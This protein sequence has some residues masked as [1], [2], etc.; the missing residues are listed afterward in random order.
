MNKKTIL[1]TGSGSGIGLQ[2][3]LALARRGHHVIASDI[4]EAHLEQLRTKAQSEHLELV[5]L[6]LDITKLADIQRAADAYTIDTLI[7]NAGIGETGPIAEVPIERIR[8]NFEVNVFGTIQLIQA[9]VPQMIAKKQG[10]I[11]IMSSM[12]GLA[13]PMFFSPYSASKAALESV[14]TS[15]RNEL[16]Y[17]NIKVVLLNPGRIDGGHNGRIAQTKY[18]W[19]TSQSPYY[20]L[21][22]EM[23]RHDAL[24]LDNAYSIASV[25]P[26]IVSAVES[27]RPRV[28]YAAPTKYRFAL[29][30]LRLLPSRTLDW[31]FFK[32]DRLKYLK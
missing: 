20:N 19:L 11:I 10:R 15:L 23:K 31:I 8:S 29:L 24:L 4:S 6:A 7:N 26:G 16:K 32:A 14:A 18:S 2:A 27:N 28:R 22:S 1:I 3:S 13:V 12:V 21:I 9:F 17:F 25:V 30:L 5:Y